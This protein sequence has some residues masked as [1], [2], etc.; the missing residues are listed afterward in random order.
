[1]FGAEADPDTTDTFLDWLAFGEVKYD[2][3][4]II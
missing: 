2:V 3:G 4:A 1:V